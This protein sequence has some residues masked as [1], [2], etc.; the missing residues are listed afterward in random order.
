M[1]RLYFT[2]V[3]ETVEIKGWERAHLGGLVSDVAMGVIDPGSRIELFRRL[4]NPDHYMSRYSRDRHAWTESFGTALR[5]DHTGDS[6]A[7]DGT[8][9][10]T[11]RGKPFSGQGLI[12]NTA[13]A[14]GGDAVKLAV[15]L[16]SQ[17]EIHAWIDGPDR[18]WVADMIEAAVMS[19]VYRTS[20]RQEPADGHRWTLSRSGW[21]TVVPFLRS[22]DTAPVVTHY[23]VTDDFPNPAVAGVPWERWEDL[24]GPEQWSLSMRGLREGDWARRFPGLQI[25][26]DDWH[27]FR[28]HHCLSA[29]DL[30]TADYTDRLDKALG[31]RKEVPDGSHNEG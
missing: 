21:E 16:H 6:T 24:S 8:P 2:T 22:D 4:V 5:L 18:A 15:R 19:G 1:S 14:V 29:F 28:F 3:D 7:P 23:S 25:K 10:M 31:F 26:P 9:L 27:T 30:F 11:W 12:L 20:L 17:S 13:V